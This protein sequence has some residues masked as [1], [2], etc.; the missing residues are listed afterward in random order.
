MMWPEAWVTPSCAENCGTSQSSS[1]V[2][3]PTPTISTQELQ[4]DSA[5]FRKEVQGKGGDGK[6]EDQE[7]KRHDNNKGKEYAEGDAEIALLGN[8]R[9]LEAGVAPG[10][11]L[12]QTL[13]G[14]RIGLRHHD[15]R[16]IAGGDAVAAK[17]LN[18]K[19]NG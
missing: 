5:A 13:P 7:G 15:W 10:V 1:R 8:L 3:A 16:G 2:A 17:H 12:I 9:K 11:I 18:D 6:N 14:G 4:A 19:Q